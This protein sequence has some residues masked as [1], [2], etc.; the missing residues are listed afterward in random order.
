MK[1][2]TRSVQPEDLAPLL[3]RPPR[4]TLAFVSDGTIEAVPVLFWWRLGRYLIGWQQGME[5]PRGRVKLLVD[6]GPWYFDLIQKRTDISAMRHHLLFGE[7]QCA[8]AA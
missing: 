7:A 4:A 3:E 2:V 8:Q 5:P 1:R 6:D